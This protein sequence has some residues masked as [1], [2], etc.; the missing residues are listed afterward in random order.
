MST[1]VVYQTMTGHSRKIARSAA[2][3]LSV[4]AQPIAGATLPADCRL[5]FIVG[6]IYSGKSDPRLIRWIEELDARDIRLAVLMGASV[7]EKAQPMLR[8]ALS[9]KGIRVLEEE[10]HCRGSFLFFRFGHPNRQELKEAAAFA[11]RVQAA[12]T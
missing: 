1:A 5:L 12:F 6:G 8:A 2:S 10:F 3:A 4:E 11:R 7:S 9:A